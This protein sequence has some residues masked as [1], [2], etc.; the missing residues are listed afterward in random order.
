[1]KLEMTPPLELQTVA[2]D[3][4]DYTKKKKAWP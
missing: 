4:A 3:F 1:M 2:H